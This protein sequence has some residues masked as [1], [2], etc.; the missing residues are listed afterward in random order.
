M[1]LGARLTQKWVAPGKASFPKS[2]LNEAAGSTKPNT[3]TK[4]RAVAGWLTEFFKADDRGP[5]LADITTADLTRML[6]AVAAAIPVAPVVA[7]AAADADILKTS[8]A[9]FLKMRADDRAHFCEQGGQMA[10]ADFETLSPKLKMAFV[11]AGGKIMDE[12]ASPRRA[13][14]IQD[15]PP[16]PMPKAHFAGNGATKTEAEFE[17]LSASEKM[18]FIRNNGR[19][20]ED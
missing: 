9:A 7:S 11:K 14:A 16:V 10:V 17:A 18:S 8:A 13:S 15:P 12:A 19:V 1:S 5:K 6:A 2:W 3:L 20:T 4:Y